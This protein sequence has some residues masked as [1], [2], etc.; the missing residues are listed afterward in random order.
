MSSAALQ[1]RMQRL[2]CLDGGGCSNLIKQGATPL[3]SKVV[4]KVAQQNPLLA[5]STMVQREAVPDARSAPVSEMTQ[6]FDAIPTART[7]TTKKVRPSKSLAVQEETLEMVNFLNLI[8][9]K[10]LP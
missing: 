10:L 4:D 2:A 7:A 8:T 1:A 3:P 6:S 5:E 9:L